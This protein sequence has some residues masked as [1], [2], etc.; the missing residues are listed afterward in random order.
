MARIAIIGAG[1]A[2]LVVARALRGQHD[3]VVYEK[4][5]GVGGRM[6]TRYAGKFEFDH[7]TQFF[8]ARSD[9]FQAYLRPMLERG[10]I[11]AWHA[12]FAELRRDQVGRIR[13][14]DDEYPHYVG[15]PRMNAV[16]KWLALDVDVI[17]STTVRS[18]EKDGD[19]WRVSTDREAADACFD[20]VVLT[21]PPRQSA[22][23]LPASSTFLPDIG[24]YTM[25]SCYALL[26]GFARAQSLPWQATRVRDADISWMSANHSKPGRPLGYSLLIHST[27]AWAD[28]H[29]DHPQAAVRAHL[30]GEVSAVTAIDTDEAEYAELHRW[31]YANID[32]Q[33]GPSY[34]IDV[35]NR[36]AAAGDWFVR[37]RVEAAF[38]SATALSTALA[39]AL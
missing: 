5:R 26:I 28:A 34:A 27:N 15:V 32:R 12:R 22:A 29:V 33:A 16:C 20:W 23:I 14:W 3:V 13:R 38:L 21:A 19:D 11:A 24:S 1:L 7:G 17:T 30:L 9:E 35:S 4:S 36:L 25:Q 18:I 2:G 31:R 37:G 10:V 6:A 39:A 8:T